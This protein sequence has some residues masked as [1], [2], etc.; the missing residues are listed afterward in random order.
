MVASLCCFAFGAGSCSDP[1]AIALQTRCASGASL[2][3]SADPSVAAIHLGTTSSTGS[4]AELKANDALTKVFGSQGGTHVWGSALL[5]AP[6]SENWLLT[7]RLSDTDGNVIASTDQQVTSCAGGVV[8]LTGVRVVYG[9]SPVPT[10]AG[11]QLSD[12]LSVVA[13][14]YPDRGV[15]VQDRVPVQV[16]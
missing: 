11:A 13:T 7:F 9:Y 12:E 10:D 1:P 14:T 15:V 5:Y 3:H 8:V 6:T 4:F 16:P 2:S